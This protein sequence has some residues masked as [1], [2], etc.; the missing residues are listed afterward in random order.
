M[1]GDAYVGMDVDEID[2]AYDDA[3]FIA[4]ACAAGNETDYE[5]V[6][7]VWALQVF[8]AESDRQVELE[9]ES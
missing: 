4:R 7:L 9:R 8:A 6:Q 5:H 3:L 2:H 1:T